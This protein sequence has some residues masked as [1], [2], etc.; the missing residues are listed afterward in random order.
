MGRDKKKMR[1]FFAAFVSGVGLW[2]GAVQAES[3]VET[4]DGLQ[5]IE[6]PAVTEKKIKISKVGR[7]NEET[8]QEYE[9]A[10]SM[11]RPKIV[12]KSGVL[13]ETGQKDTYVFVA[14][15]YGTYRMEFAGMEENM[16]VSLKVLDG[17][18][19]VKASE[20]DGK[21]VTVKLAQGERCQ[22]E[23][24]QKEK[25]GAYQLITVYQ[26][27][28]VD[29]SGYTAVCDWM[30]YKNQENSYTFT[31]QFSGRYQLELCEMEEKE[32]LSVSVC[33]ET[34]ETI[35]QDDEMR[36]GEGIV[37]D[38]VRAGVTYTICITQR[39]GLGSYRMNIGSQREMVDLSGA[40]D[41]KDQM[42]FT[43]QINRYRFVAPEDGAYTFEFEKMAEEDKVNMTIFSPSGTV[44]ATGSLLGQGDEL[45]LEKVRAGENYEIQIQQETG[46]PVYQLSI[47]R[48]IPKALF[49]EWMKDTIES[50]TMETFW[51]E[52]GE[53]KDVIEEDEEIKEMISRLE[54]YL[55]AEVTYEFGP[56]YEKLGQDT[57][58]SWIVFDDE[59][60]TL[61]LDESRIYDY[62]AQF[63]ATYD[64]YN[65]PRYF[66]TYDGS[67]VTVFGGSGYGWMMDQYSE[68]MALKE[69][70]SQ[71]QTGTKS[72]VFAQEAASWE[73]CDL[74]Y[75]YVEVDLTYQYVCMYIGGSRI[76][77]SPC[78]SG[79]LTLTDRT[80]P[81]GTYTL[82]Y[83]QS[84]ATLVGADY[85]QPVE[86][87]MPFNGGIG[88]HDATWRSA[89]G[90]D[91]YVSDGSH[92]CINLPLYAAQ[93]IYENIYA[94]MPIICYYRW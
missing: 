2:A 31:P 89:F 22:I 10:V 17:E 43:D 65:K 24:E 61:S 82:Y 58:R 90:G 74:G 15:L 20:E 78:V 51:E 57:I 19:Q 26:K 32:I 70:I 47:Q 37:M 36:D 92:G 59:N 48:E 56:H 38:G 35:F 39:Q 67:Y 69:W 77:E 45:F 55:K 66:Q 54:T 63:A 83:K 42:E 41:V 23:V 71:G 86:Y 12:T 94:G 8:A 21:S 53:Y 5:H 9:G 87:W 68:V 14:P 62:V 6:V 64:T 30:E 76:V 72:P 7:K 25:L 34:G 40:K 1:V 29:I 11:Q 91:I 44:A 3:V 28:T 13:E 16:A 27:K 80:T 84:P 50:G 18:G 73:N 46:F 88:L 75:N 49:G 93:T 79:D 60:F 52:A 33:D 85:V 4:E 81:E